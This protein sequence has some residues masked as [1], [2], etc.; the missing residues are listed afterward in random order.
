MVDLRS[1]FAPEDFRPKAQH[2]AYAQESGANL[3]KELA[4][5]KLHEFERAYSDWDRAFTRWLVKAVRIGEAQ[6][7]REKRFATK[8]AQPSTWEPNERHRA[9]WGKR[10]PTIGM[11]AHKFRESGIPDQMSTK[12]ADTN[13]GRRLSRMVSGEQD[14]ILGEPTCGPNVTG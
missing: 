6:R 3:E 9:F 14:P 10:W 2:L 5:F 7:A 8:G 12:D 11:L 13:F 4:D 1:H